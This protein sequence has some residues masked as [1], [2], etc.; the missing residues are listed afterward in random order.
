M[1]HPRDRHVRWLFAKLAAELL[2]FLQLRTKLPDAFLDVFA[3]AAA[4]IV[5]FQRPAEEAALQRAPGDHTDAVVHARRQHL[6]LD[7][8]TGEAVLALFADEPQEVAMPR[9]CPPRGAHPAAAD[10]R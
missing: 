1:Q 8:A 2:P 9:L 5:L 7:G 4:L 10:L 3:G 6:K